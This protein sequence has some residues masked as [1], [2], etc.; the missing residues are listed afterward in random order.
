MHAKIVSVS[1]CFLILLS[2]P[3]FEAAALWIEDGN[4]VQSGIEP[5][6]LTSQ[7][8][9]PDSMGGVIISWKRT[10]YGP[11]I[12]PYCIKCQKIDADGVVQWPSAIG[13][14]GYLSSDLVTDGAG[15]AFI[16]GDGY[17][18]PWGPYFHLS[19]IHAD[20]SRTPVIYYLGDGTWDFDLQY[21]PD[22]ISD[23]TG[24]AI[25]VWG[26]SY[27]SMDPPYSENYITAQ[28]IDN[29]NNRIWGD[30]CIIVSMI[31]VGTPKLAPDGTGGAIIVW[32]PDYI[33]AQRIDA[34]GVVQWTADGIPICPSSSAENLSIISDGAGGAIFVWKD[35]RGIDRDI[36]AQRIDNSGTVLW[37]SDGLSVC[38]ASG[39]QIEPCL[40]SDGA[41]GAIISWCDP[42]SGDL[43]VYAQRI[44]ASGTALWETDG[45]AIASGVGDQ[46]CCRIQEYG[47][48]G[49]IIAYVDDSSGN[50]DVRTQHV[51]G[52][53]TMH[54]GPTGICVC[55]AA[56][57][58]DNIVMTTDGAGGAIITW[59]DT[60]TSE[61]E[62]I[63]ASH[64]TNPITTSGGTEPPAANV[65]DQN[66]PNPFNPST[67][68][69]FSLTYPS[70]VSLRIY[71][72][73]GRFIRTLLD[74]HCTTGHREERWDGRDENGHDASSGVYFC[75]IDAGS[76]TETRK[77]V[78][79]R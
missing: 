50:M 34:S 16:I 24:G 62:E 1:F 13:G 45:L 11:A 59:D 40:V 4:L 73:S 17:D 14:P 27:H 69:S 2:I 48:G 79:L 18:S 6:Y 52:S 51:D 66:H 22:I 46:R 72:A 42:R 5:Y 74:E 68:I 49:S 56:G 55:S 23:D 38:A 44:D 37:A 28:R 30:C 61:W 32:G 21:S 57:D 43:D 60:R 70:H 10:Y 29:D 54:W 36:Y 19:H 8:I 7:S 31:H 58:Q 20:G 78:L 64:I 25:L 41:G 3:L 76:F 47:S 77:M 26:G 33:Y 71:D 65:L 15:G 35:E 63:Y 39:D 67:T 9:A 53:G 12:N 75:R